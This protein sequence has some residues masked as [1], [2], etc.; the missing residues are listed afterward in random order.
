MKTE[1]HFI[2]YKN[3]RIFYTLTKSKRKTI[4][5]KIDKN[6]EVKVSAP[7]RLGKK[8]IEEVIREKSDWIISKLNI[9]REM[10]SNI[11]PRE[12]VSGEK[13]LYLGKEYTLKI[14]DRDLARSEVFL[15]NDTISVYISASLTEEARKQKIKE[16]LI[17]WYRQCFSE[18]VN[19]RI[20]KYS[21][22][23]NATPCNVAIKDQRTRWGSCSVKGNINLNWRLVMAPIDIIDYVVVH[24]LCHLKIMNHSKDFWLLVESVLPCYK[25]KRKWLKTYG[26]KLAI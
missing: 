19:D 2:E 4:G 22:K 23:L 17:K 13:L 16:T 6:G 5:I 11:V 1:K 20:E 24:E 18:V 8:Q 12:F 14:V 10:N 21:L 26:Y 7:L 3:T 9:V 25:E 15:Q